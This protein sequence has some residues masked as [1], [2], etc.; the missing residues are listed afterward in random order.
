MQHLAKALHRSIVPILVCVLIFSI[1]TPVLPNRVIAQTEQPQSVTI[2]GTIQSVL[3][4]PGDWQPECNSTFMTYDGGNDIWSGAWDLPAGEYEYKAALNGTWDENYGAGAAAGGDNIALSLAE[5]TTVTFYYSHNTHWVTDNVNSII[6]TVPGSFQSEV[7]CPDTNGNGGDWEPAC[8][9]SW[10]QDPDGDGIYVY[11]APLIPEGFFEAKVAVNLDWGENYGADGAP[12]GANIGFTAAGKEAIF[13]WNSETKVLVINVAGA[14]RGNL[15][16]AQAY[17][18]ARDTIAWPID[19]PAG[20]TFALQYAPEGGLELTPEGVTGGETIALT[21]D[22]AGLNEAVLG[23]FPHLAGALVLKLGEADVERVPELLKGQFVA[24]VVDAEGSALDATGLQIP[25]VLD[26][27]YIYDGELGPVYDGENVSL[28]VWAPT[29]R[30]VT[31]HVFANSNEDTES[32]TIPME[33]DA[34]TGVWS[35]SGPA[36]EW[37]GK[38]Y[39]YEVEVFVRQ[40]GRVVN[41]LVTDP[42]SVSL[43]TNSTRSQIVN[44]A[45]AALAP[46]GW[47]DLQKP[48]LAAPEDIVLYELHVRD[49]SVSDPAVPEELKGT[50]EAFT[51]TDSNGMAHLRALAEAGLT[52][53]HL[54]PVF[55]LATINENRDSWRGPTFEELAGFGPAASTQQALLNRTRNQDGFNW[56]YDPFHYSVPEGSYATN[57]DG[58]ARIV[59]FRDMVQSLNE[60]GLRVVMDVVYNH[61]NASGQGDNSVL[62]RIV[63]GYYHRLDE[64]GQVA[65]STCCANTATEH[66][67]MEKLM[68]DS[69][70]LWATQYKVDGF[71][72]DLM[73]HHMRV[74]M[75]NVRAALDAL[76][77]EADGVDGKSIYVYG[78]GWDFGE[79]AVNARGVNATQLNMGGTGIGTFNDRLRDAV[80][81]GS[82][83]GGWQDQ[84]FVSGL[85][86][87]PNGITAGTPEEQAARL[88]L[89][90]DQIKVGLAG[91]LRDYVFQNAAGDTVTGGEVDYNGAPA[92]YTLDPQ[93]HI[94]YAE[95]HDNETLFDLIQYKAP[96]EATVQDRVRMQ[97]LGISIVALSQGVPFFHAGMD[98]LR[99]KSLDKNSYDSG[100]WFNQLDFTYQ[101]NN[102]GVGLPARGDNESNWPIIQPL[103]ENPDIVPG[104]D[105]IMNSVLHFR[106]MLQ[107]RKSVALFR[108]Q[109]SAQIQEQVRFY[110]TGPD[111]L[112]G[113]IV[114]QI[115]EGSGGDVDP[116]YDMVVV[117]FNATGEDLTYTEAQLSGLGLELHPIQVASHDPI[118]QGSAYDSAAG[119]FTVPART[120]AVFVM[121]AQ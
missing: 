53:I 83:F 104:P 70:V 121:P 94:V 47:A 8:L 65:N 24:T 39:L 102:W 120:T 95:A 4:C 64:S 11:T 27:L 23:K 36:A 21:L 25:G 111:Q 9:R 51:L 12:G 60:N 26:D 22:E 48:P 46:E 93:E 69:V 110:N 50:Y 76:T 87:E 101:T 78:E 63:P 62:D 107:I 100:D 32:T 54:L 45:D 115:I 52:H 33:V 58:T 116:N 72:F 98:M 34:A 29:A 82:P 77:L 56:G 30:S 109:T 38:F 5:D 57:P 88:L 42:Y 31:L 114:M 19:A 16:L 74:N 92:G 106:E 75:E 66:A 91:N 67:M 37:D 20:S 35:A 17:W 96:S 71:R 61:T 44:L 86:L 108:L 103:L 90:G 117:V 113:V 55:D 68:I 10:L 18:V 84:G 13:E 73:G 1:L 80:R 15:N 49:F 89:F 85:S 3:G 118:V 41:N 112:P 79:V 40:E 6:A 119:A 2:A 99:S 7:G 14:P 81:G 59:E 97:N 105:D 43:S 28:S